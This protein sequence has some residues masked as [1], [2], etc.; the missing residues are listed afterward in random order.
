MD[1]LLQDYVLLTDETKH[2]LSV[3]GG[4]RFEEVIKLFNHFCKPNPSAKGSLR[5]VVAISDKE[6]K[7]REIAI[8]DYFSQQAL[9]G[10]HS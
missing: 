7:T 9:K 10:L 1:T 5:K 6:G 3:L 8:L 2:A 4:A